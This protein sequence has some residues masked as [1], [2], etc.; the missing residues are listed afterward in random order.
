MLPKGQLRARKW[1]RQS[2]LQMLPHGLGLAQPTLCLSLQGP[3]VA[4]PYASWRGDLGFCTDNFAA[5]SEQTRR[6]HGRIR[7]ND[8]IESAENPA[9]T[10]TSRKRGSDK[11]ADASGTRTRRTVTFSG[12]AL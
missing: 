9:P 6:N 1:W 3:P 5:L 11:N 4:W 10:T 7:S 8:S 12:V 2:P